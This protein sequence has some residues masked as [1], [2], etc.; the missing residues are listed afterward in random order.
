MLV[1]EHVGQGQILI[2]PIQGGVKWK[3]LR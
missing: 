1:S 2:N 3:S